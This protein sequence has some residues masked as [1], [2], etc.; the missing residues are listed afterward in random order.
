LARV[1]NSPSGVNS[2]NASL[3]CCQVC[4]VSRQASGA[5]LRLLGYRGV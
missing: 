3:V 4:S 2:S 5:R 1:F